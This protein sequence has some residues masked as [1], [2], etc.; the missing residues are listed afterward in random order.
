MQ[1]LNKT[2]NTKVLRLKNKF[3]RKKA[4]M[5]A[6]YKGFDHKSG[7]FRKMNLMGVTKVSKILTS[8][9]KPSFSLK[10]PFPPLKF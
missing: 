6:S 9:K 3:L 1:V 5:H 4:D 2:T 10:F 7:I 8:F